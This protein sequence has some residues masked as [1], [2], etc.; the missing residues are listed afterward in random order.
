MSSISLYRI[1]LMPALVLV[2]GN[3]AP[4]QSASAA[5]GA[6]TRQEPQAL[7]NQQL[8]NG[9]Q[10][11]QSINFTLKAADHDYGGHRAQAVRAVG[12]AERQLRRA[13]NYRAGAK[14]LAPIRNQPHTGSNTGPHPQPQKLSDQQLAAA[15]PVLTAVIQGLQSR[16][17][18][19]WRASGEG[20]RWIGGRHQATQ[21]RSQLLC[22][23]Q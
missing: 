6:R 22:Q 20:G 9:I 19:L 14:M 2:L 3:W 23:E 1:F 18:R 15:I 8:V 16:Q 13:L 7:S 10:L 17:P 4:G 5:P 11:L 12:T 21:R